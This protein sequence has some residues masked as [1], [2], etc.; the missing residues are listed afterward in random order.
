MTP[1]SVVI[2]S[3]TKFRPGD[4][5]Y[6]RLATDRE[7]LG[8]QLVERLAAAHALPELHGFRAQL[9]IRQL[10]DLRFERIDR[11]DGLLILLD[12]CVLRLCEDLDQCGFI[13]LVQYTYDRKPADKLWD[14]SVPD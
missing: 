14:E 9:I 1:S 10:L 11:R 12:E 7:R 2:L 4:E 3:V 8:Q 5:V 6:A 13:K